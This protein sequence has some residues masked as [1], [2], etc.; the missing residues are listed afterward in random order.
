MFIPGALSALGSFISRTSPTSKVAASIVMGVVLVTLISSAY[1]PREAID[2]VDKKDI[3]L[4]T[5]ARTNGV[6]SNSLF[7]ETDPALYSKRSVGEAETH[8]PPTANQDIEASMINGHI[9]AF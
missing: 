4:M 8:A 6:P 3:L 9:Q 5:T 1:G 7:L 2:S